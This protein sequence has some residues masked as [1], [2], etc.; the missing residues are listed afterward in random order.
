MNA[1][2]IGD[3]RAATITENETV[4]EAA[5]RMRDLHVGDLLVV[6]TNGDEKSPVGIL[7]EQDIMAGIVALGAG[8]LAR[9]RVGEMLDGSAA[10]GKA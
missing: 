4:A 2:A 1:H 10:R 7:T 6:G 5:R 8:Q 9:L 3:R